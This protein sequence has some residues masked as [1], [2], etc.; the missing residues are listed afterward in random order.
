PTLF[1]SMVTPLMAAA[2]V[3]A[4][5]AI[6]ALL[7]NGA[8]INSKDANNYTALHFTAKNNDASTTKFLLDLK[9]D[10]NLRNNDQPTPM[11]L[12]SDQGYAG[13]LTEL[14]NHNCDLNAVDKRKR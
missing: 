2:M 1:Q 6:Q 10:P 14:A 12:A 4:L 9:A 11:L 8:D 7:D 5:D 13:V 3:H